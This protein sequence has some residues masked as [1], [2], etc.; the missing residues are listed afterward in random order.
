MWNIFSRAYLQS[1][2]FLVRCLFSAFCSSFNWVFVLW[3]SFKSSLH[4]LDNSLL[5]DIKLWIQKHLLYH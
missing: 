2:S 3:L 4:I 1:V 5:S